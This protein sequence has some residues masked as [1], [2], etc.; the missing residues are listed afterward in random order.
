MREGG[1]GGGG[2]FLSLIGFFMGTPIIINIL[3][4]AVQFL[5]VV[6]KFDFLERKKTIIL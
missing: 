4:R 3:C 5:T 1:G 6:R 2:V